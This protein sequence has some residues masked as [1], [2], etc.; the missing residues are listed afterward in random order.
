MSREVRVPLHQIRICSSNLPRGLDYERLGGMV[1]K[2]RHTVEDL[3]PIEVTP[4]ADGSYSLHEG[5]HRFAAA[6]IGGRQDI[7]AE[8]E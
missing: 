5:R 7:L 3:P 1:W 6:W 2:M 4:N 8:L